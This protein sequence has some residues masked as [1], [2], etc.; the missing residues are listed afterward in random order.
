LNYLF[1]TEFLGWAEAHGADILQGRAFEM[2]GRLPYQPLVESLPGRI[3]R[4]NAPD[5]LL[6]DAWLAELSRLLPNLRDRYPGL[7]GTSRSQALAMSIHTSS[8]RME[9]EL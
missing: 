5:D 2:G 8:S 6:S 9:R 4:E 1:A 7:R 3:E